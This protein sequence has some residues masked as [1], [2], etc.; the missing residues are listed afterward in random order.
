MLTAQSLEPALDSVSSL[1]LPCSCSVS[2]S[3]IH[4]KKRKHSA[5]W[6]FTYRSFHEHKQSFVLDVH[7]GLESLGHTASMTSVDPA[8]ITLSQSGIPVDLPT[9]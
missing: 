5:A 9:C 7:P 1:S 6:T 2:L 4:I 8:E 3:K